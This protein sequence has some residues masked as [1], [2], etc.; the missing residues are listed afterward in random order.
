MN[1]MKKKSCTKGVKSVG[2]GGKKG[3]F[4]LRNKKREAKKPCER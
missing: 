4:D 2:G 3:K 1:E